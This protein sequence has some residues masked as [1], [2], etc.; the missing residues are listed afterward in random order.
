MAVPPLPWIYPYEE[1]GQR[2]LDTTVL[3]PI[4]PVTLLSSVDTAAPVLALVDSGCEHV[5]AAP[6]LANSIGI[7][8]DEGHRALDLGIGGE[9]VNVRFADVQL[10]LHPPGGDDDHY[11]EWQAEIGFPHTWRPMWP[12]LLGQRGFFDRFTVTMSR[13]SQQ[14]AVEAEDAFDNRFGVGIQEASNFEPP[15]RY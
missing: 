5:L 8:P 6:W 13:L 12:M 10:R 2:R 14:V 15:R 1:D 11:L 3:R 9:T 4:V 7:D